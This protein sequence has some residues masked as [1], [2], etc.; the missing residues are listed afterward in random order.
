MGKWGDPL[1]PARTTQFESPEVVDDRGET[2]ARVRGR[3]R[4]GWE[5]RDFIWKWVRSEPGFAS[6]LPVASSLL[7]RV[8]FP[9]GAFPS[10]CPFPF[11]SLPACSPLIL[12]LRCGHVRVLPGSVLH[13]HNPV[14]LPVSLLS[15][16]SASCPVGRRSL[17]D[18]LTVGA[19]VPGTL[20]VFHKFS[21]G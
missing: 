10:Y 9:W 18:L 11:A 19:S 13:C 14:T 17:T 21:V 5:H 16:L 3:E 15:G 7:Q 8:H 20:K 12:A 4:A 1:Q 2:E 6:S